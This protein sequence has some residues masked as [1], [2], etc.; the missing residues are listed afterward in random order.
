MEFLIGEWETFSL[1]DITAPIR[2]ECLYL[3]FAS[4]EEEAR[5]REELRFPLTDHENARRELQLFFHLRYIKS[6]FSDSP[7]LVDFPLV[8]ESKWEVGKKVELGSA[9]I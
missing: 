6:Q 7:A 9:F 1:R 5:L 4:E 2:I 3:T 8:I